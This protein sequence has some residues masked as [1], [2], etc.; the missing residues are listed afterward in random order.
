MSATVQIFKGSGLQPWYLRVVS[1]NGQTI[2]VSEGYVT[3][4]NARRAAR[5]L[6]LPIVE[7]D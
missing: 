1:V 5:K 4:W 7:V 2:L 6:G 3:R